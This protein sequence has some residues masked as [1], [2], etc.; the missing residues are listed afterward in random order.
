M[1]DALEEKIEALSE[2]QARERRFTSDV[3]HELRTP[4]TALVGEASLLRDHLD[5]MPEEARRPAEL[6][7]HDVARLRRL[8]DEL[9]EISR[10]DSGGPSVEAERVDL[11]LLAAAVVRSRGWESRVDLRGQRVP[12]WT[13]RRRVERIVGNLVGN[14]LEHGGAGV[15]V[16]VGKAGGGAAIVEVADEGPGI[17]SEHLPH[18]FD[19]FYKADPSRTGG[20]SGLGLAIALENARLLG[21]DIEVRS[22]AGMGSR[23]RLLLPVTEPLPA[24]DGSVTEGPHAEVDIRREGG[25]R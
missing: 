24:G 21:G 14:A 18:I 2:A 12:V 25:D 23:F 8:V 6:L 4:L 15:R 22:E 11:T 10:L 5:R 16:R 13:D 1:A 17:P 7:I 9:M 3:A 20:G 19:R